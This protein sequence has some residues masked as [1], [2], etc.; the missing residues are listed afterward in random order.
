MLENISLKWK[1]LFLALFGPIVIAFLI[2]IQEVIQIKEAAQLDIVHK[3]RAVIL[4]S[5]AARDEMSKKLSMGVIK[6]FEQLDS[7]E[8]LIEA[9][10]IIT[11]INMAQRNAKELEFEFRVPKSQEYAD[12]TGTGSARGTES[13]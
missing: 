8:A 2:T 5:E 10:P 11:A 6:P 12:T 3:S 7:R 9:V 4:M 13:K 1:V